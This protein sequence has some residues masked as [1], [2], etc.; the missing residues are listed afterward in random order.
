MYKPIPGQAKI[1]STTATPANTTPVI[2]P[3]I[4]SVGPAELRRQ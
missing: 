4:A 2:N 1:V 3:A